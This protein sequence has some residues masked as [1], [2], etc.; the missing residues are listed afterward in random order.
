M[1]DLVVKFQAIDIVE[2]IRAIIR[3]RNSSHVCVAIGNQG[4]SCSQH[5]R[6]IGLP[7]K[8]VESSMQA[9]S[10]WMFPILMEKVV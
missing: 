7:L 3:L 9:M 4:T 2:F 6:P 5:P 8:A 10:S 1:N